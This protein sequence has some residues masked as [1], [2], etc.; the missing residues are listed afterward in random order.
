[1]ALKPLL[2]ISISKIVEESG[3]DVFD[4]ELEA[5]IYST[6]PNITCVDTFSATT[7]IYYK[8]IQEIMDTF[9]PLVDLFEITR[10]SL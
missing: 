7:E 9:W 3:D 5:V 1:M 6:R 2:P 8:D 10:N 4:D